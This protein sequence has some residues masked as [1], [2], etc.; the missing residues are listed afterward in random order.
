MDEDG[1][2]GVSQEEF[3]T[4]FQHIATKCVFFSPSSRIEMET[5]ATNPGTQAGT[6]WLTHQRNPSIL[7]HPTYTGR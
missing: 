5:K 4:M 6:A 3:I 1:N 7:P 2:E